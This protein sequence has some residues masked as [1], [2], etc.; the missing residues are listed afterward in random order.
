M[1]YLSLF[2]VTYG[3]V[4]KKDLCYLSDLLRNK[5]LFICLSFYFYSEKFFFTSCYLLSFLTKLS[6]SEKKVSVEL[7]DFSI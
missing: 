6:V 4:Q 5:V 1:S 2:W 7:R 3:I